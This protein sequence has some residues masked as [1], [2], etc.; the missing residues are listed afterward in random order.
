MQKLLQTGMNMSEVS[1]PKTW[2]SS[3]QTNAK[4]QSMMK[5]RDYSSNVNKQ[6]QTTVNQV[7]AIQ[8]YIYVHTYISVSN[9]QLP[10]TWTKDRYNANS[11]LKTTEVMSEVIQFRLYKYPKFKSN[12]IKFINA[13]RQRGNKQLQ[14]WL[15]CQRSKTRL[16]H[17]WLGNV[18]QDNINDT[19]QFAS[20]STIKPQQPSMC[21]NS[22]VYE[23]DSINNKWQ[24]AAMRHDEY[25]NEIQWIQQKWCR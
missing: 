11:S 24:S 10:S 2:L 12:K 25:R 4:G 14:G 3:Y 22:T 23:F 19:S 7:Q 1:S 16:R 21:M 17:Q 15:Q 13:V 9:I 18:Q 8:I 6:M 20:S 5:H